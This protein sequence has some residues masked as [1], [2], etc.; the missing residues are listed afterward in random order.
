MKNAH[1]L[2][3]SAATDT[4]RE[5]YTCA[6]CSKNFADA[7]G[8]EEITD[9]SATQQMAVLTANGDGNEN[10]FT[11]VK[12]EG[13]YSCQWYK[14]TCKVKC[15]GDDYPVVSTLY[16][17]YDG[18]NACE[19]TNT[20]DCGTVES[21]YDPDTGILTGYIMGYLFP[22]PGNSDYYNRGNRYAY[23]RYNPKS[24]AN[25]AI[26]VGNGRYNGSNVGNGFTNDNHTTTYAITEPSLVKVDCTT[27][28]NT[29]GLAEAKTAS[30]ISENLIAPMTDKTIDFESDYSNLGNVSNNPLSASIGKWHKIGS[31]KEN[32]DAREIPAGV[33]SGTA[34]KRTIRASG[35]SNTNNVVVA[36]YEMFIDSNTTYQFDLDYSVFSG[37]EPRI[38]VQTATSSG[39]GN[40]VQV[41]AKDT[42]NGNHITY[43]FTSGTLRNTG[44][45]NFR[46]QLG[47]DSDTQ[48]KQTTVYFSNAMLR[49]K[50]GSTL[51]P[52]HIINGDFSFTPASF[53]GVYNTSMSDSEIAATI[54]YWS[55]GNA[56]D[57][58]GAGAY[59]IGAVKGTKKYNNVT[60]LASSGYI[61]GSNDATGKSDV[62]VR[63]DGH[64]SHGSQL[65]FFAGLKP[66]T[67][68]RL[69]FNYRANGD[70]PEVSAVSTKDAAA[71]PTVNKT[72][73]W[74]RY[75]KFAAQY[76]ITTGSDYTYS[77]NS[78][79][80][81]NTRFIF[82]F[83]G[84]SQGKSLYISGVTLYELSGGSPVGG[85]IVGEL[86]PILADG[87]YGVVPNVGD[88]Y[89]VL[90]NQQTDDSMGK[91]VAV[92]W[93]GV[94]QAND[95]STVNGAIVKVP[96]DFFDRNSYATR[97]SNLSKAIIGK[98]AY[99]LIDPDYDPNDDGEI[100][101]KDLVHMKIKDLNYEGIFDGA[102]QAKAEYMLKNVIDVKND[103][104]G[105]VAGGTSWYV[106]ESE[107]NN[108]NT[109]KDAQHPLKWISTANSKASAG[110]TIYL[111][112]GD[113]WRTTDITA[114]SVIELKSGVHYAAYG[115]G[116]K[117]V[118][119]GSAEDYADNSWYQL[120]GNPNI[121][122]TTYYSGSATT[123]ANAGMI[124]FIDNKGKITFG[125]SIAKPSGD[126]SYSYSFSDLDSDLEFF[127]PIKI[128]STT[129]K[130]GNSSLTFG[131]IYV[132]ST[133]NPTTRFS[134]IEIA[135][136]HP[137]VVLANS[138]TNGTDKIT[139]MNNIAVKYGGY[140]GV[141]GVS[142]G[143][144]VILNKCEVAYIGGGNQGYNRLGNGVEFGDGYTNGRVYDSYIHDCFDAGLTFQSYNDSS[145]GFEFSYIRFERNVIENCA[146]NIE[147]FM[148]NS[149]DRMWDIRFND[150]VLRNAGYG[151][152]AEQERC[153]NSWRV[154]N[155]CGSKNNYM[156]L[157]KNDG[158]NCEIKN[159]IFDCTRNVHV[160]WYWNSSD[161]SNAKHENLDVSGNTY[162]QKKGALDDI[163]SPRVM[164]YGKKSTGDG[165]KTGGNLIY[166]SS[167]DAF[168]TA[169][170]AFD[171]DPMGVYWLDD[172]Y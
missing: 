27:Y 7:Y 97:I 155:I 34:Q 47:V 8:L 67:T 66:S 127:A 84:F 11:T 87:I 50:T 100:N 98:R 30:V 31:K 73:D 172:N 32:I 15:Y 96:S 14:F 162:F 23:L 123:K 61:F 37:A 58:N 57:S 25:I 63:M 142:G 59:T 33:F 12:L 85:N 118:I 39:Y 49:K 64:A 159:N 92:G 10:I 136:N 113:T 104:S 117:P 112:R 151:Q 43:E 148:H 36:S 103:S 94:N 56:T 154:S 53:N 45:G 21:S 65:Q 107:G 161:S 105:Y 24:G 152:W 138:G 140:H 166:A 62:A 68:Y 133:K 38:L 22:D 171:D 89:P 115:S 145:S 20:G 158:R 137:Q 54:P 109:G 119:S 70:A 55:P 17:K 124:Y 95:Y 101:V 143:R 42:V 170:A 72:N 35:P 48:N 93:Y 132:Y 139:T 78:N 164:N 165:T 91:F 52:N 111:K 168:V 128:G 144:N 160:S 40:D 6:A 69:V 4:T 16:A 90:Y 156:N 135:T 26:V 76:D 71:D 41:Y 150:N 28:S 126:E 1:S 147:F 60:L 131:R 146:Y 9:T 106:S 5:Y 83:G 81:G 82:K 13:F 114:D 18:T 77:P 79:G 99:N 74:P 3:K 130:A 149:N 125:K 29:T 163:D 110:D 102:A 120:S 134:T 46:I 153:D 2:T 121:W 44:D 19:A 80:N 129:E 51:G 122:Y 108:S 88:T 116:E 157:I 86:N 167:R 169:V 75:G 141:K